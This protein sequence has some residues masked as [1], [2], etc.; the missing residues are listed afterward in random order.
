M[1]IRQYC[2]MLVLKVDTNTLILIQNMTWCLVG[3]ASEII[4]SDLLFGIPL[5]CTRRTIALP[6]SSN[7]FITLIIHW[8][9]DYNID[10]I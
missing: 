4:N 2:M 9:V 6:F 3:Y 5:D 10:T 8:I 1:T 7:T